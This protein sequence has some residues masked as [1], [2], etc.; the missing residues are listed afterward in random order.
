MHSERIAA[1]ADA[2]GIR[3][4]VVDGNDVET[5]YVAL[6]RAMEYVRT[7]RRPFLLEAHVSRLYGHTSASGANFVPDEVDC[8]VLLENRLKALGLMT[9]DL[10]LQLR[11]SYTQ[12][13][14]EAAKAAREEP[15][16]QGSDIYNDVYAT[17]D[18]VHE[19]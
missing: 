10:M 3:S 17:R 8:L 15:Q 1:R 14:R 9:R 5:C 11:S 19:D 18:L 12:Q 16:P 2:F 7:T 4:A 13:L 6:E